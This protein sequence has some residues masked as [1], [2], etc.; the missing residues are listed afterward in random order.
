MSPNIFLNEEDI[1]EPILLTIQKVLQK[2]ECFKLCLSGGTSILKTLEL[3]SIKEIPWHKVMIYLTDE[4][5]VPLDNKDS[6]YYWIKRLMGNTDAIITPF[7]N[8]SS[9]QESMKL[10]DQYL[11]EK[12]N[13]IVCPFDLLLL[14]F[15]E[16]GH[17]ASLFPKRDDIKL[18]DNIIYVG[19]NLNGYQRISLGLSQLKNSTRTFIISYGD[20]KH[21]ILNES[22]EL[23][24]PI[25]Q[26]LKDQINV[27]WYHKE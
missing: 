13:Q 1:V 12:C 7:Y 21:C 19:E 25:H 18:E 27:T 23:N 9:E 14:G 17:I 22:L 20:K 8:G 5:I 3:L 10:Y 6:N 15:G 26:F 2:K 4:R 24:L 16:D 11:K